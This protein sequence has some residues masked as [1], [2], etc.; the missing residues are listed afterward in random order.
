MK[1]TISV[2]SLLLLFAIVTLVSCQDEKQ[3]AEV[4]ITNANIW[5]GNKKQINAQAMAIVGDSIIAIGSNNEIQKFVGSTTEIVD[6]NGGFITPGF[7]DTHVHLMPSGY[8]LSG[9][10]KLRDVNS[11]EEFTNSIKEYAESIDS[12]SWILEGNWDHT[13]WGGEL[14][15]KEW[16]DDVTKNNPVFIYRLDGHMALA[17]S[18]ALKIAGI[19]KNTSKIEGGT[20]VRNEDG[21]PTGILKDNAMSLLFDKIPIPNKKQNEK[22]FAA[23]TRYLV[24]KGVTSVHD[25][26][27][28]NDYNTYLDA[29]QDGNLN[30]RIYSVMPL[31]KWSDIKELVSNEGKGDKWLQIGGLKGF[32]D[33]SL[34]SHTAAFKEPYSDAPEDSGFFVNSQEDLYQWISNADKSDLQVM[35]HAIGDNAIHTLLNIYERVSEENGE[36]DRRFRIEHAQ[37]IAENDIERF[38]KLNIIPSMQPYHAIDDGRW[39]EVLIGPERI[40]TTY[41]FNSLLE[42]QAL[43]A[44]GSD[45]PVAPATPLEGI[46]AAVTRRTLDDKNPNGWVPKQKISV[47]Q[48][49]VAYTKNASYAGF[50]EEIKGTLE[51]GKLAD[52]V[53]ISEDITKVDPVRIKELKVLQTYVGGRKVFDINKN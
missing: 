32:V 7:I 27:T 38:S 51:P 33:G 53:V 47:D 16:I 45:W 46:Y 18:L 19:D 17:N 1:Q 3:K 4:I 34:G 8:S 52:F 25:M 36:K 42:A 30:L 5:T 39:A 48:A 31:D 10:V 13:L 11:P 6:V 2:S 35:V 37:H 9:I 22:A 28:I 15:A 20:I 26:G 40:K 50:S 12:G 29:K 23:A 14:P 21:T 43:L 49:L 44:F 41:A 24:S